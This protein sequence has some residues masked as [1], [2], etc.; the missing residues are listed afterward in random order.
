MVFDSP[1]D[2][3]ILWLIGIVKKKLQGIPKFSH[4]QRV[5]FGDCVPVLVLRNHES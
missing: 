3:S 4:Y 5:S 1:N 2:S